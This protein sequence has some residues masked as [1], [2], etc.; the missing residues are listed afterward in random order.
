VPDRIGRFPVLRKLGEGG[1]GV[2]Y[3]ARDER[4]ARTVAVKVLR[5]T[6]ADRIA[7]ERLLREARA[8][9]ALNHPSFC[10][11]FEVG[12]HAGAPFL[13]MELLDGVP[14][15]VRLEDGPLAAQDAIAIVLDLLGALDIL[16][17]QGLVHRDLKPSNVFLGERGLKLLDFGLA[18]PAAVT[19]ETVADLTLPGVLVG[20]PGYMAPEQIRGEPVDARSDIFAAG[21][22]FFE[23]L[24][25]RRPFTGRTLFEVLHAVLEEQ[26]PALTGSAGIVGLDRIIHKALAKRP[27]QRYASAREMA[28]DLN[29]VA[30]LAG[31]T[32]TARA[33]TVTRIAVLPFRFLRSDAEMDFLS[34]A[35]SDA[36]TSSLAGFQSCVVRSSLATARY[37]TDPSL[38]VARVGADLDVDLILTGTLLRAG[39]RLRVSVEL[40]EVVTGQAAW[41]HVAQVTLGD[42]F[43]LQDALARRIVSSLPLTAADR[44][45][46][47][48]R[49]VPSDDRAYE[50]YLRANR[51]AL[52]SSTWR[53]ARD[54]YEDCVAR[55]PSF[56]PAWARL[57]RVRRVLGKYNAAEQPERAQASAEAALQRALA[58]SPDLPG[59]HL[60]LAQ[61]ETDMGRAP[62]SMARL[63]RRAREGRVEPEI[64]AG[65][66]HACR[67]CGLLD[68]SVAAHHQA[69]RF[70]PTI[71]T[72]VL[73]TYWCQGAYD[74][75]L[76]ESARS[77]DSLHCVI[78]ES[79]GKRDQALAAAIQEEERYAS[80]EY[81][82]L[83]YSGMRAVLEDRLADA[84]QCSQRLARAAATDGEALYF[85]MRLAARAGDRGLAVQLFERVV[86][87]GFLCVQVFERDPW[88]AEVR[89]DPRFE[90]LLAAGRSRQDAAA[91]QFV[92]ERG[93]AVLGAASRG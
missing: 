33:V 25:G 44:K 50:L 14:L 67:Y 41:S 82:R 40:V 47:D 48:E 27:S 75:A 53:L 20:S 79:M 86:R 13:V 45:R 32:D 8:A 26:P 52:E 28:A 76:E 49:E 12:E 31:G 89:H 66:V 59:A 6:G 81:G 23:M 46:I 22:L 34:Y 30:A 84:R 70:D 71:P 62:E 29:A 61:L 73:Y 11:I 93:P 43:D 72:S 19:D 51:Y 15:S 5:D 3:A 39:E 77:L 54:L 18:R 16:H 87:Q 58:L 85:A 68:A 88:L 4:L 38:D 69:V 63:L 42:V 37:G 64:L 2:V 24:A 55:D 78:L 74:R 65:L 56:A 80:Q 1:M 92:D 35:L 36:V 91:R 10:Q 90:T 9:A 21:I 57:G 7:T 83:F 60:Y 17:G